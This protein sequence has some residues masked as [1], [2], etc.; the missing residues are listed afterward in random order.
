MAEQVPLRGRSNMLTNWERKKESTTA[1]LHTE[2]FPFSHL[3]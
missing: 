3:D 2:L 1:V